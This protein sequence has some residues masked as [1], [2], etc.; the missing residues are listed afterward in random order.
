MNF[1][2]V[3]L[4][5]NKIQLSRKTGGCVERPTLGDIGKINDTFLP[6]FFVNVV[7]YSFLFELIDEHENYFD[8]SVVLHLAFLCGANV[9]RELIEALVELLGRARGDPRG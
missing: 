1:S 9:D 4:D 8:K 3:L 6:E 2:D 7:L 5:L